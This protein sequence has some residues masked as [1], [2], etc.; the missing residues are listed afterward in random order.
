MTR[1]CFVSRHVD[2]RRPLRR[3]PYSCSRRHEWCQLELGA[4]VHAA[5]PQ[6]SLSSCFPPG[7]CEI[8]PFKKSRLACFKP[9]TQDS[10]MDS[11]PAPPTATR[12]NPAPDSPVVRVHV[13]WKSQLSNL[14]TRAYVTRWV[15]APS[16][17]LIRQRN[18]HKPKPK[19]RTR[20]ASVEACFLTTPRGVTRH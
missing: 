14:Y 6:K 11:P 3:G 13:P 7:A 16:E 19:P 1:A 20:N 9:R 2:R 12:R 17:A 5:R 18:D 4:A 10:P 15:S 8:Q